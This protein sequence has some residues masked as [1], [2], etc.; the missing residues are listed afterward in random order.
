MSDMSNGT[1]HTFCRYCL[2]CCGI[3]V[4][5]EDNQVTK[6]SPDKQNPHTWRDFC[7]KG[8]TANQLV[9]HPRRILNPMRR[10]GDTYVEATWDE[11][12]AD[13]AAR[14][15]AAIDAGGPDAVGAYYGNPAGFS[16]SNIIFYNGWLDAIGT[17]SRYSVGS[18]DQNAMHVVASAM[19]G[20]MLMAPVSDIDNCDYFL[21]VGTN[22]AVSAWNWL[23]TV[24]GG[25]KRA[26]DR[27]RQGARIVVVDPLHTE[28]VDKADVHLS[29]RPGQ[30]WAL[31]LAMVKIV[32]EEG[33]EHKEDCA[34]LATGIAELRALVADADLD[35]LASRCDVPR[36][37]IEQVARDF[38][39]ASRAMVVTRTGV[40]MHLAGTVAEWLGHV[41]NVITGRMDRPGGRRFEPGYV[42]AVGLAGRMKTTPHY[43]RL[44]NRQMVAGAHALSEL[45]DEITTSGPGQIRAM[46]INCGNPVISGPDG[47]KLD[48]A[49]G[50]L[51]LLVAI[52]F[53]QRE[54]H[55]HAHWL[56]PAVHWLE[57]DDLL[58]F[59][60]NMH[61]EPYLHFGSKAVEPPP[62]ARQE[63]RIFTDLAI[64]MRKP[65]FKA[66]GVNTFIGATRR[67]AR[68]TRRPQLE[69]GPHWIDR[70]VVA[71][72]RKFNGRRIKWRDVLAH[73][74]GWV[75]GPREFGHF[76]GALRTDDKKVHAAPP[77]FVA[78]A[79]DL[80]DEPHP[81]APERYPFQLANRRSRHSMNSWLNELPGLHPSGKKNEVVIN[82]EDAAALGVGD[83]DHVRVFSPVGEIELPAAVSKQPRRGVVIVDHGWGSKV[84]DPRG[85]AAPESFG[86]NRN[87][88]VD[89]GPVDPLSQTAALSSSY[90]GVER[91]G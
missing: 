42:D 13:I 4:T 9:E 17:H 53:V 36:A 61:D 74:H 65:L 57:R 87:L 85:G 88:L 67:I 52:D 35:D 8:R 63:W 5:V 38:A 27:K 69:F 55:R 44:R 39:I 29:V 46:V 72:G 32:L 6:I 48:E 26:L 64:A 3:E 40:S 11:A 71:T 45:P 41:L 68:T 76:R 18:V 28:T 43:S 83:G 54:S 62:G 24:P 23:E 75:L 47:R 89:G 91:V 30:D 19:Y 81:V 80:L 77:E 82:P 49:F 58:A 1:V 33:L 79:R 16:S 12:I 14:M 86:A 7:A 56:L 10:V 22:P 90:V 84:F 70:L 78:R 37:D 66:K 2:A 25:W 21:L 20:S 50:Q 31:L 51:D 34:D 60:S 73:P 15:N 59:T